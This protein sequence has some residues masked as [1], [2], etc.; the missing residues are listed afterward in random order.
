MRNAGKILIACLCVTASAFAAAPAKN[1]GL[2]TE[3]TQQFV[4]KTFQLKLTIGSFVNGGVMQNG[5][6]CLRLI[7]TEYHLDGSVRYQGRRGCFS[8]SGELIGDLFSSNFYVEAGRLTSSLSAG[9]TVSVV[10]LE[11]KDDRIELWLNAVPNTGTVNSYGKLKLYVPKGV[12]TEAVMEAASHAFRIEKY[13]R[14]IILESEY[15]Q[16]SSTLPNL[17][18][19][20]AATQDPNRKIDL[21]RKMQTAYRSMA[22]NRRNVEAAGGKATV[23]TYQTELEALDRDVA[24]LEGAAREQRIQQLQD[25]FQAN[26][27]QRADLRPKLQQPVKTTAELDQKVELVERYKVLL[28]AGQTLLDQLAREGKPMAAGAD[29]IASEQESVNKA[30]S[31]FSADRKRLQLAQLNDNKRLQLTQLNSEFHEMEKRRIK[32]I[33]T[34]SQSAGTGQESSARQAVVAVLEL[35][36]RN[37][38]A[39][40]TMGYEA[41]TRQISEIESELSSLKRK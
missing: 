36:L 2:N 23:D 27:A 21:A 15:Q 38:N 12:T 4:G 20:Y 32:L 17:R 5:Q 25:Q 28:Q 29:E 37:R 11:T 22:E 19:E 7:D 39:A 13:E 10:K 18:S 40:K 8:A 24:G 34:Y 9:T 14:L 33:G 1:T 30:S 31:S 16:L 35:M 41:A 6:Q 26:H 3:L